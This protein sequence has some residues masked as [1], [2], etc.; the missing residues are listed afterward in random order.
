MLPILW[1]PVS[2]LQDILKNDEEIETSSWL[3][4]SSMLPEEKL[5]ASEL[6]YAIQQCLDVLPIDFRTVVV[7]VDVLGMNYTEV[8]S[9]TRLP[10]G[11]VKSR[12]ARARLHLRGG[13]QGYREVLPACRV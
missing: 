12:L 13:L 2:T 6:E 9:A 3:A 11:T 8:A 1:A 5:E 4:D 10:V 7:L